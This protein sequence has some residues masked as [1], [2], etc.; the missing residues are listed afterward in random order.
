[1]NQIVIKMQ[2]L[3]EAIERTNLED[4]GQRMWAD[5]WARH[6]RMAIDKAIRA[7]WVVRNGN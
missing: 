6:L 7:G 1:V 2:E 3:V 5:W 4:E